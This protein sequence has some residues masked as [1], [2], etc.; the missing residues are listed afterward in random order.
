MSG[1][2]HRN[3]TGAASPCKAG[4]L[5]SPKVKAPAEQRWGKSRLF[6]CLKLQT[7]VH[8]VKLIANAAAISWFIFHRGK[9]SDAVPVSF[10]SHH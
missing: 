2:F 8:I 10:L 1:E 4:I 3:H 6:S 7:V 9:K 5:G